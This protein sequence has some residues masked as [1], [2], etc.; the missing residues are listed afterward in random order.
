VRCR[1]AELIQHTFQVG[2]L[3]LELN[4]FQQT[5]SG[6]LLNVRVDNTSKEVQVF[7]PESLKVINGDGLQFDDPPRTALHMIPGAHIMFTYDIK[8]GYSFNRF[9]DYKF[10]FQIWFDGNLLAEINK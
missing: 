10:P 7:N 4:E 1:K 5:G 8:G 3:K 9:T 2:Q 6:E